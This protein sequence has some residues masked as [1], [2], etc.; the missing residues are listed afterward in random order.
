MTVVDI[1]REEAE[2]EL[3]KTL[4]SFIDREVRPVEE[5]HLDEL[6]A[7]GTIDP[8]TQTR[9]RR[10]LRRRS[11]ELGFYGMGLPEEA[12]GL[13]VSPL[14]V[15]WALEAVGQS[16]LL[17]ADRGGVLPNVEGPS[18]AMVGVMN[19]AQQA[20]YLKPLVRGEIEGCWAVTEPSAG[21]DVSLIRT[22]AV[23][24]GDEWLISG[25]KQFITHGADAD[26][27]QVV[28]VTDADLGKR[29]LTTFI[30][31]SGTEGFKVG[32]THR[33]LGEDR[34]VDLYFDNV[35]VSSEAIVGTRGGALAYALRGIGLARIHVA[36]LA[37]G[38]SRYLLQRMIAQ[39]NER[40]AF[41]RPI[42][43]FQMVQQHIVDSSLEIEGAAGLVEAAARLA[44]RDDADARRLAAS[45]K[46]VATETLS[47]V[48]DRA[49]QVFGGGGVTTDTGIERYYRDAR[50]MRIYE[51]TSEVLRTSIARWLGL[52][53]S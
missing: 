33:T 18:V 41:G 50:A 24:Q 49:I 46:V 53:A 27:V 31:D 37:L 10:L 16:G 14:G 9:E 7:T 29:G 52:P 2:R 36:A 22:R 40:E 20:R 13:G 51:G 44:Q 39:A 19:E 26:F 45:A 4:I 23:Q 8:A 17:L 34:P 6:R 32:A 15:A 35:R 1:E 43:A 48:A 3:V 38:K 47:R 5:R 11:A 42:G 25:T 28:A 21:S 30:V 12:G